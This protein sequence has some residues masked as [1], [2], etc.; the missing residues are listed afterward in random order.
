MHNCTVLFVRC[1]SCKEVKLILI[2]P[3][4]GVY[5]KTTK[6]SKEG[7]RGTYTSDAV[8]VV[9]LLSHVRLFA[10]PW[11]AAYQASLPFTI[12]QSSLK[13]MSIESMIPPSRLIFCRPLLLLPSVFPSIGVFSNELALFIR[14]LKSWRFSFSPSN[15]YS[16]WFPLGLTGLISTKSKGPQMWLLLKEGVCTFVA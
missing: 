3:R 6:D 14:W 11:T 8:V 12:S 4:E 13:L 10:T 7:W 1:F 15:E 2:N 5:W 16:G 9:Q